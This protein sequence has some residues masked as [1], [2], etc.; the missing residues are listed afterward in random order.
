MRGEAVNLLAKARVSKA[1]W[2]RQE[3]LSLYQSFGF[4]IKEGRHSPHDKVFH[5]DHPELFAFVPRHQKLGE[6][7]VDNAIKLIDRLLKLEE[8]R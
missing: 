8:A 3:L 5:P 6:Y 4:I 7:N 1:G 2:H